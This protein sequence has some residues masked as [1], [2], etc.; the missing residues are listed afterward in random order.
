MLE[1]CL[2]GAESL[3]SWLCTVSFEWRTWVR[4]SICARQCLGRCFCRRQTLGGRAKD[5]GSSL[6]NSDG[7]RQWWCLGDTARFAVRMSKREREFHPCTLEPQKRVN[8]AKK[9]EV[10][11]WERERIGSRSKSEVFPRTYK[12]INNLFYN[13]YGITSTQSTLLT[14]KLVYR[15]SPVLASIQEPTNSVFLFHFFIP[16]K[17]KL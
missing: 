5:T 11:G 9:T 14:L 3:L 1:R 4:E 15:S 10:R 16:R 6:N 8:F 12:P 2:F 17:N 13:R 7:C